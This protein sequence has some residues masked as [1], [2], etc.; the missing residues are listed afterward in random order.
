MTAHTRPTVRSAAVRVALAAAAVVGIAY[1]VVCVAIVALVTNNLTGQI[2]ARLVDNLRHIQQE[3]G[4]GPDHGGFE[5][6][7]P[8][9]PAEGLGPLLLIWTI[10]ADGTIN[11][12]APDWSLTGEARRVSTPTTV[13]IDETDVRLAG[14]AVGDRYVVVGQ[15]LA[16]VSRAQSTLIVVEIAL[17]PA[18]LL[19]VFLGAVTIGRRVAEPIELARQRQMDF[20]ADASHEL[21]T[22]L[23]VIEAQ[24]SLALSQERDAAWYKSAFER[25]DRESKRMRRLLEDMLWLARFDATRGQPHAEP[26]DLGVL[27]TQTADRFA[28]VAESRRLRLA[29]SSTAGDHVINAPPEWLDRLLGVLL[30]NACRYSPDG[31][32]V[33]VAVTGDSGRVAVTVDDSGPGIPEEERSRIFDR[34]HR[35]TERPGGAGLGLAIGDA[36]VRATNGR[37]RIA[38]SSFGGASMSVSWPRAF[39]GPREAPET[40]T[41]P[42][43]TASPQA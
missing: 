24:T 33:A 17:A 26:L 4:P 38:A 32:Q 18:L 5:A 43:P 14:T 22:P 3:P 19:I 34:F 42:S 11:A 8:N 25:V 1:L 27:A 21:R 23:S 36:I 35:A 20:T 29:V 40:A 12:S 31:G 37:W 13:S 2:D 9:H 28:I 15:T 16:D 10:N 41:R 30:D 6:P 7:A 39:T